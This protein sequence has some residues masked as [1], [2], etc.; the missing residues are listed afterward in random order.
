MRGEAFGISIVEAMSA[1]LIPVVPDY[2]GF[3]EFVPSKYQYGE[4]NNDL[5]TKVKEALESPSSER[6]IVS[7]IADQFSEQNFKSK[8][9][10][11]IEEHIIINVARQ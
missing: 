5:I 3:T 7:N 2:G 9:K 4:D 6:I 1:G 10:K 11:L 8:M